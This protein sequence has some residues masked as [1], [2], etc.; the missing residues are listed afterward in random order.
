M[1]NKGLLIIATL[2]SGGI[3]VFV[4]MM[5]IPRH[6]NYGLGKT[7]AILEDSCKEITIN[8]DM[9]TDSKPV[10]IKLIEPAKKELPDKPNKKPITNDPAKITLTGTI[11]VIDEITK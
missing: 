3:L 9:I 5:L 8:S 1:R 6:D 2:I 7:T 4:W 10:E 11:V